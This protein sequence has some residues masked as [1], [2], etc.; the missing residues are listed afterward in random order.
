MQ[1]WATG[2]EV[3]GI[4]ER[5]AAPPA[6]YLAVRLLTLPQE[7]TVSHCSIRMQGHVYEHEALAGYEGCKV[8]VR[9]N[10]ADCTTVLVYPKGQD[11]RI[12]EAENRAT[13][14]INNAADK[15]FATHAKRARRERDRQEQQQQV[16]ET[17]LPHEAREMARE[18]LA[19][20]DRA[21]LSVAGGGNGG[22]SQPGTVADSDDYYFLPVGGVRELRPGKSAGLTDEQVRELWELTVYGLRAFHEDD[23]PAHMRA[24]YRAIWGDPEP[25]EQS[26]PLAAAGGAR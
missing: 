25:E 26:L 16:L 23:V 8:D 24:E 14:F 4:M 22:A 3:P 1:A 2:L 7:R 18:L 11:R 9:F 6:D 10:I 17:T 19:R 20:A 13:T 5:L 12:C 21:D 15:S